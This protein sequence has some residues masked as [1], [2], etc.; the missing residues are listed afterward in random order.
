MPTHSL[1]KQNLGD[2]I[3]VYN[4]LD[5]YNSSDTY[6]LL[7]SSIPLGAALANLF[8]STNATSLAN[9]TQTQAAHAVVLMQNHGFTTVADS[10]ELAVMQAVY[11]Q[12]NAGVQTTAVMLRGAYAPGARF[13]CMGAQGG[14]GGG[15][16]GGGVEAVQYLTTRETVDSWSVISGTSDRPWGLWQHEVQS[17]N[18]YQNLLDPNQTKAASPLL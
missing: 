8:T 2:T 3:P 15:G 7:V 5:Y 4:I 14:I 17:S 10:I 16:G 13:G 9:A 11:T 18:L 1:T 6:D 12:I